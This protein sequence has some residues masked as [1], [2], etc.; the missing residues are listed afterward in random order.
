VIIYKKDKKYFN[1]HDH[2]PE[3]F[4]RRFKWQEV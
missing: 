2:F 3:F 1:C 4:Y